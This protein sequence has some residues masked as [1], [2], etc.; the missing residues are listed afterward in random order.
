[1]ANNYYFLKKEAF[2][3]GWSTTKKYFWFFVQVLV[4]V[5]V[6]SGILSMLG[7]YYTARNGGLG[8]LFMLLSYVI[9]FFLAV[10]VTMIALNV[11]DQKPATLKMLYAD[12][13]VVWRYFLAT[14]LYMLIILGGT[15]LLIVPGIIWAIKYSQYKYIVIEKNIG[16]WEA[17]KLSGRITKGSRWNIFFF[18]VLVGLLNVLGAIVLGVGLLVTIPVSMMASVWVYRKL[19]GRGEA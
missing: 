8:A 14:V 12:P 5:V 3:Y 2:S 13:A 9:N 16:P 18:F 19:L 17:L 6:I 4:I 11:F 1:M 15:I 7:N 10:G